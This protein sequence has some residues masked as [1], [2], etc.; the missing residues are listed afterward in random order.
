M[1]RQWLDSLLR[2]YSFGRK[3]SKLRFRFHPA[4]HHH[5]VRGTLMQVLTAE[6]SRVD[7]TAVD[8][9]GLAIA[10]PTPINW[11]VVGPFALTPAPDGLSA[12]VVP[13]GDTSLGT[14][15]ATAGKL[16][17]SAD[18]SYTSTAPVER[19]AVKLNFTFTTIPPV[20]PPP[21]AAP[22]PPATPDPAAPGPT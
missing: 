7:L 11:S 10:V 22:T 8:T 4:H 2:R 5:F 6:G 12:V 1:L 9:D 16:S 20:A 19:E 13:N 3:A 15:N 18:I 21:A 14:L 17:L